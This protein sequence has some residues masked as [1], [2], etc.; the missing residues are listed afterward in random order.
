MFHESEKWATAL[1]VQVNRKMIY[2]VTCLIQ[3]SIKNRFA[4]VFFFF[5]KLRT[6]IKK[7]QSS[8]T[9]AKRWFPLVI[10]IWRGIK[11]IFSCVNLI[12]WNSNIEFLHFS[13]FYIFRNYFYRSNDSNHYWSCSW[14]CGGRSVDSFCRGD[15][16]ITGCATNIDSTIIGGSSASSSSNPVY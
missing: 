13:Y 1:S 15:C 5:A 16:G 3:W 2:Y 7:K 6:T 8:W 4:M 12:N 10:S 11:V 14:R 9:R